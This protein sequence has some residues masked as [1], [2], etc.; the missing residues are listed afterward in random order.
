MNSLHSTTRVFVRRDVNWS[1]APWEVK[2]SIVLPVRYMPLI[3]M[4]SSV[5]LTGWQAMATF[6]GLL[7]ISSIIVLVLRERGRRRAAFATL[8]FSALFY[9]TTNLV[10][11]VGN[12]MMYKGIDK[13]GLQQTQRLGTATRV[14]QQFELIL[15]LTTVALL[16]DDRA[17]SFQSLGHGRRAMTI[18]KWVAVSLLSLSAI[19]WLLSSVL[20]AVAE[21]ESWSFTWGQANDSQ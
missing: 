14:L 10:A 3:L 11:L 13:D 20:E 15:A 7:V 6:I 1:S 21:A 2:A 19:S 18:L 16:L 17:N 4:Q 9:I 8:A 5:G 12:I